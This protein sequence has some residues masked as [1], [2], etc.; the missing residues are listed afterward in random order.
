MSRRDFFQLF[1]MFYLQCINRKCAK[2]KK[3]QHLTLYQNWNRTPVYF[4]L[5]VSASLL[6]AEYSVKSLWFDILRKY[7][8]YFLEPTR[9]F[10]F[11]H[12]LI[13]Q[14]CYIQLCWLR[15]KVPGQLHVTQFVK[16]IT[17]LRF[18]SFASPVV[19]DI[20]KNMFF[21]PCPHLIILILWWPRRF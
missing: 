5:A 21:N 11:I 13:Y 14:L 18:P 19:D 2:E 20:T 9:N 17:P 4:K 3:H 1:C 16:S 10:T 15:E 12:M 6:F 8:I 7:A